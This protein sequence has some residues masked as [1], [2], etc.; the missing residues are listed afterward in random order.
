MCGSSLSGTH[1]KH[2]N[3]AVSFVVW[4]GLTNSPPFRLIV[5]QLCTVK[6]GELADDICCVLCYAG[7]NI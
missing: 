6:I 3:S 7:S 4:V 5:Q 2:Q 1:K